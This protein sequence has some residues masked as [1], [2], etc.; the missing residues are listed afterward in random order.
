MGGHGCGRGTTV[1][2]QVLTESVAGFNVGS[3]QD[4]ALVDATG[5]ASGSEQPGTGIVLSPN[6]RLCMSTGNANTFLSAAAQG[7]LAPAT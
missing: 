5:R 2:A 1:R 3:A 6:E 4:E 7:L